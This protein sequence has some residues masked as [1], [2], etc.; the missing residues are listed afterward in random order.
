MIKIRRFFFFS[1]SI[2]Q[3]VHEYDWAIHLIPKPGRIKFDDKAVKLSNENERVSE[4]RA[5]II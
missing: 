4:S 1:R 5:R 2:Y 3:R